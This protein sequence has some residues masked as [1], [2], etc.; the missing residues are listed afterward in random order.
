MQNLVSD[1]WYLDVKAIIGSGSSLEGIFEGY[2]ISA[3]GLL[4]YKGSV[5]VPKIGDLRILIMSEA[6]RAPYSTH[7]GVKKMNADL[8]QHYY[9]PGMKRDVT[10]FVAR[11]LECQR[12]KAEHQHPTGLLQSHN[13]PGWKWD[14]ISIDF[15]VGLPLSVRCHDSI[16]VVVDRLT[17]VAHFI[18]VRSSYNAASVARIYM[19]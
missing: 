8:R 17:K 10:D 11:C 12:V 14:I 1:P 6:H 18:L 4:I 13:V 16:M 5:Y 19:E 9:W 7:P 3:D 15:I 2:S